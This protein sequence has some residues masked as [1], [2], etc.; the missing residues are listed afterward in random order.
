MEKIKSL[1]E[2]QQLASR[3]CV[4]LGDY[5][6]NCFHMNS[7]IN[8]EI[9]EYIDAVKRHI[10]YGKAI[11]I[12]NLGEELGDIMWYVANRANLFAISQLF[13]KQD[14]DTMEEDFLNFKKDYQSSKNLPKASSENVYIKTCNLITPLLIVENYLEKAHPK[15]C[16]GNLEVFV[17]MC[18][19]KEL[20]LDFWEILTKNIE[21]LK[22]RYPEKFTEEKAIIRNLKKEREI[23]EKEGE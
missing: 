19:C 13:W 9:G 14:I 6:I 1:S 23:L 2:Y 22:V 4:D 3:T 11:D 12:V 18:I 21:K 8:T 15:Y 10:A 7:G 17:I 5:E 20:G 16:I